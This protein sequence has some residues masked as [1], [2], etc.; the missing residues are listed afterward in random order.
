MSF[1][2]DHSRD[3]RRQELTNNKNVKG[4]YHVRNRELCSKMHLALLNTK[5]KATNNLCYKLTLRRKKSDA[6][7]H[8]AVAIADARTKNDHIQWYVPHYTPSL[9]QQGILSQQILSKTPTELR[10][11]ERSV[12]LKEANNQNLVKF[13]LCTHESM[14]VPILIVTRCQQRD[15]Q[16]SQ[17][18]NNDTFCR[19]PVTSCQC[20]I[21]T[22][23]YRNS[24]GILLN[25]DNDDYSQGY[26]Q[27]KEAFRALTK[28]DIL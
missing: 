25:N 10:F 13:E 11:V 19:L 1:A 28:V 9:Q 27:I 15:R 3:R 23:R 22:E 6:V 17:Y 7:L 24:G 26:S 4:K 12:L 5:K 20:K 16:D 18:L 14:N 8:K 2:F 21:D